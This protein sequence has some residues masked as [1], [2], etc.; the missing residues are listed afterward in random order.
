MMS[1][2]FG[3]AVTK[4]QNPIDSVAKGLSRINTFM[5]TKMRSNGKNITSQ[6]AKLYEAKKSQSKK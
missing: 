4:A 1:K 3:I 2:V 5:P 6:L